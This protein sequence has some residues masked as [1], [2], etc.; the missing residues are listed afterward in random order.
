MNFRSIAQ[1]LPLAIVALALFVGAGVAFSG[2][3]IAARTGEG[4]TF[5]R[6]SGL[7]SDRAALLRNYLS[8]R[9]LAVLTAARSETVQNATRDLHFGW[10]KLGEH[11]GQQLFDA[12]VLENPFPADQRSQLADAG[13]GTN[14]DSA[15]VRV[16]PAL[17]VLAQSAG[18]EEVYL[19]DN[20]GNCI[21]SVNKGR[22]F[23]GA[24]AEG[25]EFGATA[26]GILLRQLPADRQIARLSDV[27]A[28][29]PLANTPAAFMAAAVFDKRGTRTGSIAVRLPIAD[30]GTLI[31]GR[32]GLGDTGEVV[33]VGPDLL[34]RTESAFTPADDVLKTSFDVPAAE[35][36]LRGSPAVGIVSK[37]YRG[38][39]M[40][41]DAIPLTY[42]E[43][44]W[45]VVTM[46]SA[47]EA[48][49]PVTEMGW[50]MLLSALALIAIAGI[51][52]LIVSRRIARPI[53]SLTT[54]MR[55]LAQ[56]QLEVA[57]PHSERTDE[58]GDMARAVEVF[59]GSGVKVALM[60]EAEASRTVKDRQARAQMMAELR[61]AFGDVVASAAAGDFSRRI[62]AQF[63]DDELSNLATGINQLV[64]TIDRGLGETGSVLAA[65]A[66]ADLTERMKGEYSGA[67]STLKTDINKVADRLSSILSKVRRA[68]G[69]LRT[70]TAEILGSAHDLSQRTEQQSSTIEQ[71]SAA[72]SDLAR[73]VTQNADRAREASEFASKLMRS[74]E[75]SGETMQRATK[76]MEAIQ[77]SSKEIANIVGLIDDIAFQTNLL[78]LNASVEAARAG[79]AGKGFAVVA[80]EVRRLAQS[81]AAASSD[82]KRLIE[83][84]VEEVEGGSE[85]VDYAADRMQEI[86]VGAR[87]SNE[88]VEQ[89]AHDSREQAAAIGQ[90][91]VGISSLEEMTQHNAGL[92]D[93]T[94]AALASAGRQVAELDQLVDV[95]T[96][97][98]VATDA[99]R[100]QPGRSTA[101]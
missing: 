4:L 27:A 83:R 7:A 39:E 43:T 23:A 52:A 57:V 56:G 19:F 21:F 54:T 26:L 75:D 100:K 10:L 64:V 44:T 51:V 36:A 76:S 1:K 94:N 77:A 67:F 96:L 8:S 88:L 42:S 17:Q 69:M 99:I 14:Y 12:Y 73:T 25:G 59:R 15:H 6:L 78:A 5:Q 71:T 74:A 70:A 38:Q 50:A 3:L 98:P 101:A 9:E 58:I 16:Q 30:F 29:G 61:A 97:S 24:F 68:T 72:M 81:A 18:F 63:A 40:L 31:N 55:S 48:M 60:T 41:V 82:I 92:V 32:E 91:C 79:E 49:A 34:L 13:T 45:A 86:L 35:S 20:D 22:D 11:P 28:Y 65:L 66:D 37:S 87:S 85:L 33:I 90:V 95:F 80:V 93:E 53:T 46:M 89:I 62:D 84:S 47:A 2:Y